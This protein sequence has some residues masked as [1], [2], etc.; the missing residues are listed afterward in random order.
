MDLQGEDSNNLTLY[1][2][3]M[4]MMMTPWQKRTMMTTG[5]R[6]SSPP[7]AP[8][9]STAPSSLLQVRTQIITLSW[10]TTVHDPF[11]NN[12]CDGR[13]EKRCPV[14]NLFDGI[15]V[16]AGHW[17]TDILFIFYFEVLFEDER[18]CNN[19]FLPLCGFQ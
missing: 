1:I 5:R 19:Y 2:L 18:A 7:A 12:E 17:H 10:V 6:G 11:S 15:F 13:K 4:M 9:T 16:I 8:S 14:T 3:M